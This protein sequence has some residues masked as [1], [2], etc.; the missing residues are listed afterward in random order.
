V[1]DECK[2]ICHIVVQEEYRKA[3]VSVA[4]D[5]SMNEHLGVSKSA[6]GIM[7]HLYGPNIR[8]DVVENC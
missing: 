6:K 4:Y 1:Q 5:S 7:T 3:V 8:R 2:V